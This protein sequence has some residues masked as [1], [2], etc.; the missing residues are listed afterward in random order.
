MKKE[1]FCLFASLLV[2][3]SIFIGGCTLK[4]DIIVLGGYTA[5]PSGM[6]KNIKTVKISNFTDNRREK[7]L[8]ATIKNLD[9]SK[10]K[11]IFL[12]QDAADWLKVAFESELAAKTVQSTPETIT[13]SASI[14]DLYLQYTQNPAK[15]KNILTSVEVDMSIEY[16]NRV[17]TKTY[18]LKNEDYKAVV[19]SANELT[20]F[21]K[22][23][24][25]EI[26]ESMVRDIATYS[27]EN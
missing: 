11:S 19:M 21:I 5:K 27:T 26:A 9:G 3:V 23:S 20:P 16:A 8:V 24:L 17:V 1:A 2:V 6:T 12:A 18:Y 14:K 13:I 22:S 7:P 15:T 25:S 4:E 10:S